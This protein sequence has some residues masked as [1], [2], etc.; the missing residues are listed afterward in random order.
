VQA[1]RQALPGYK[2]SPLGVMA[3]VSAAL[4][5]LWKPT[6]AAKSAAFY[7]G[8]LSVAAVAD[9]FFEMSGW[10]KGMVWVNGHALARF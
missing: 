8:A 10:G 7:R 3:N 5:P 9:T 4:K 1:D 6:T 2:I